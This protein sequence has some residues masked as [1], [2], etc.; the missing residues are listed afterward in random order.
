M[1]SI[2][3]KTG[4]IEA[5]MLYKQLQN[6]NKSEQSEA[7]ENADKNGGDSSE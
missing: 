2:F 5:Y 1:W 4:N 6:D 3:E 7:E